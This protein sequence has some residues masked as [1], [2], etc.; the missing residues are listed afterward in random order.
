MRNRHF[1]RYPTCFGTMDLRGLVAVAERHGMKAV[2]GFKADICCWNSIE[3]SGT[4]EQMR[5]TE[6][7]WKA[8]GHEAP[9][10]RPRYAFPI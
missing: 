5:K 10:R 1:K 6:T 9:S 4:A 8:A 3:L 2:G 7:V